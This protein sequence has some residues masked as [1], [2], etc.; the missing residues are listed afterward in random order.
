M[1]LHA[2]KEHV[3]H[4]AAFE[5]GGGAWRIRVAPAGPVWRAGGLAIRPP[6][7]RHVAGSRNPAS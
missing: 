1:R 3:N 7:N 5:G 2:V 6:R 4:G